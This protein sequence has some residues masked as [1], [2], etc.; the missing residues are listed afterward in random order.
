MGT[1]EREA[2]L[3]KFTTRVIDCSEMVDWAKQ[4]GWDVDYQ[5]FDRGRF[6]ATFSALL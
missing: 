2:I 4:L 1:M 5:Q 6:D 3:Q